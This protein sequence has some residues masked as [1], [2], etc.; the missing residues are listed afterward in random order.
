MDIDD[1]RAMLLLFLAIGVIGFGL[2]FRYSADVSRFPQF[3]TGIII[4]GSVLLLV[5][6]R[7]PGP[8][9]RVVARDERVFGGAS[10]FGEEMEEKASEEAEDADVETGETQ[11]ESANRLDI[12]NQVFLVGLMFLY[13]GL[14]QLVGLLWVTPLFVFVYT[15]NNRK[16][17][18][19]VGG[20]TVASFA[21]A[22][23]FMVGLN[24]P[25]ATGELTRGIL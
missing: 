17:W 1:E 23:V 7:L 5:Q 2:S 20:L 21:I 15:T 11:P 14:G 6:D 22:Y 10:E 12:D 3:A 24:L 8:V 19:T 18:P 25:L 4:V 9:R 16:S 13:A